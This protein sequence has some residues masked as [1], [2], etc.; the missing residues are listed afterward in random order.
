M[1]KVDKVF[2]TLLILLAFASVVMY[3]CTDAD[4]LTKKTKMPRFESGEDLIEAFKEAREP[5]FLEK[6]GGVI[7]GSRMIATTTD[8]AMEESSGFDSTAAAS[9]DYSETN[10]QVEGVDEA[11]IIKT[12]GEYIYTLS[13]GNLVIVKAYPANEAEILSTTKIQDFSPRELFIHKNKLL[14]FGN[15]NYMFEDRVG[16]LLNERYY[17]RYVQAMSVKLYDISDRTEPELLRTVDFEG[18]YLTSRKIKDEVYFVVTSYPRFYRENPVCEEILPKYRESRSNAKPTSIESFSP[19][20]KCTDVGYIEPLQAVNFITV[21]SISMSD[22]DKEVNKEVIVGSGGNVYAS[23]ENLYVAQTVFPRYD[24]IV[25]ELAKNYVQKTVVTK[26]GLDDGEIEFIGSG[27]VKGFILNQFSMDEYNS[28]FRIATTTRGSWSREGSESANHLY[29]LDEDLDVVGKLEDLAPGES[30]YSVRF[31]G[32]RGYVVTFKKVDPLFVID[33][34][35]PKDPEVLGKLKI[36]GYSNYMHPYDET[37]IIGIGK[38]AVEAESFDGRPA[39]FA[40]YQGMKMA[41]F[42]VSDVNNPVEMHKEVI[43]DRGTDSNVLYDHK[44]FLFDK[45][46]ELLVIPIT[47]AEIKGERTSDNQHGDYTFQGAYVYGINLRDGFELRGRVT[48]YE[49]DEV[50]KKSGYYFRGDR[51]IKRSLYISDVLY[52]LSDKILMM[53]DLSD[54]DTLNILEFEG[55]KNKILE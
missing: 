15:V 47:L 29:V 34:S 19:V 44:A 45:E 27:E 2:L 30:I 37:H 51:Q 55:I 38:E 3:G 25:G 12:D 54:L 17:P 5:S 20:T 8:M 13:Q 1:K 21:A 50:F 22:E 35:D 46:K 53:N 23:K 24:G 11:D 43:G 41:I 18:G 39:D 40:W 36:P 10:I 42:D 4:I 28:H 16:E 6:I 9:G 48:H 52:T 32:K 7:G 31:M 33:L 26:F 14:V 49:D